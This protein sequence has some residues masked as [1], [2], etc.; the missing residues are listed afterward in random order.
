M[1]SHLPGGSRLD[2]FVEI[3]DRAA[4]ARFGRQDL[5][6]RVSGVPDFERPVELFAL[7]HGAEVFDRL[8]NGQP[9]GLLRRLRGCLALFRFGRLAVGSETHWGDQRSEEGHGDE[10]SLR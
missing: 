4:A 3:G 1:G 5:Q 2:D 7:G 6:V 9:R 8:N 10:H